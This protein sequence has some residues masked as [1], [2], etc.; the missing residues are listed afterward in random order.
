MGNMKSLNPLNSFFSSNQSS[1]P[2]NK[3][4]RNT[5]M[6]KINREPK[7]KKFVKLSKY[8]TQ[9][10]FRFFDYNELYEFGK[11]NLFFMNNV[12]EYLENNNTWPEEVRKLKSKYNFEIHQNEVDLTLNLAKKNK[13]KYKYQKEEKKGINY[14]QFNLDGNR[15]ISIASS[16]GWAHQDDN[17]Y[18]TK[19]KA[20]GSYEENGDVYYLVNVCWLDTK[21]H[22]Y[23]V[24][25]KNN[26][27]LYINEYFVFNKPLENVLKLKVILGENKIV[28]EKLFPSPIM[29]Q[30]NSGPKD[31]RKLNEDFICYI[32]KEDFD[33]VQKDQNGDCLV[34]VEFFHKNLFWKQGWF[35]DGG[36]LVETEQDEI[37]KLKEEEEKEEDKEEE[38]EKFHLR[39]FG[40]EETGFK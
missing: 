9:H 6:P 1:N 36:C 26:Y 16:F 40:G 8:M 31:N 15:Y 32:K 4:I 7:D 23:H 5:F 30:N 12:I 28:Y 17:N 35:I 3:I 38:K 19:E 29:Y 39:R 14:Y 2:S 20:L 21:F 24:N 18:W 37:D 33:D 22:F 27:K 11:I 34:K 13:R 10:M 25:P